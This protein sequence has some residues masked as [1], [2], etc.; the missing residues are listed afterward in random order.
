MSTST[1]CVC[2]SSTCRSASLPM[3][4]VLLKQSRPAISLHFRGYCHSAFDQGD[5]AG[6]GLPFLNGLRR[7]GIIH[8]SKSHLGEVGSFARCF[9]VCQ[10]SVQVIHADMPALRGVGNAAGKV[11]AGRVTRAEFGGM[12]RLPHAE[13]KTL[14]SRTAAKGTRIT[15][16]AA[17]SGQRPLPFGWN[18]GCNQ[19]WDGIRMSIRL[20]VGYGQSFRR[21]RVRFPWTGHRCIGTYPG[22]LGLTGGGVEDTRSE[23]GATRR[24]YARIPWR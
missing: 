16:A 22:G 1:V 8:G 17:C 24:R 4:A 3:A 2:P 19:G 9:G 21:R 23:P 11:T 5:Q 18:Q 15:C 13:S 10:K 6:S 14:V 12:R 7:V 20:S